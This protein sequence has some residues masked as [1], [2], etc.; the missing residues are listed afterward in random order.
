MQE[1]IFEKIKKINTDGYEFWFAREFAKILGYEK[2]DNFINVIEK[3]RISCETSGQNSQDHLADASEMVDVGSG[4][5]REFPSF[6][7]SRYACYLIAQNGDPR[8][9]AIAKAQTYFAIKTRQKEVD[10]ILV[11]DHKRVYLRDEMKEHNKSLASTAKSAGVTNYANFQDYGYMGLY[12]G[13]RQKD[14]KSKKGLAEKD[15][16]LDHMN[17]E[18]LAANLFR[19]TQTDAKIKRENITGQY[20]ASVAHREVGEKVRNTIKS[21]GGTMPENLPVV[22]NIKNSKKRIKEIKKVQKK[23]K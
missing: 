5:Q 11:E 2:F 22:E 12:G 16:I 19:A 6:K 15:S 20:N 4:A 8:K 13:L 21:L 9:V 1:N 18:E 14:I 7:L 17:S 10:D 23:L 3:A